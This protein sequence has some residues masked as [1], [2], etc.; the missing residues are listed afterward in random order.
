MR[1][2]TYMNIRQSDDTGKTKV[3]FITSMRSGDALGWIKWYGMWR[4]YCFFPADGCIFNKGCL[5]DIQWWIEEAMA[6]WV[7]GGMD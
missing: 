4:Q 2:S 7:K 6:D 1:D 5:A 3:W